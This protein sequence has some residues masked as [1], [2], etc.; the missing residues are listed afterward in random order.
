MRNV[1]TAV[2]SRALFALVVSG[3]VGGVAAQAGTIF[4]VEALNADGSGVFAVDSDE[5]G[6]D[7]SDGVWRWRSDSPIPIVD[8]NNQNWIATLEEAELTFDA[9]PA[10]NFGFSVQAGANTT[11]FKLSSSLITLMPPVNNPDG[12]ASA[13]ITATDSF[14]GNGATVTG[15]GTGGNVYSAYY[16]GF[17]P[18]GTE[19][20]NLVPLVVAPAFGSNTVPANDGFRP[21]AGLVS[22]ISSQVFFS[23]TPRD[24][25]SGTTTFI[26]T[27]E[28]GSLV[29]LVLA[30]VAALRR[31]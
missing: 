7:P 8:E 14:G 23:L 20:S 4:Q 31:R 5:I 9:D 26:V 2:S 6:Y 24:L 28:P 27:P 16:N 17:A 3:L 22:D 11:I 12:F 29:L 21:I 19:F 18:A 10:V 13:A 1:I 15:M 30:G 25:A